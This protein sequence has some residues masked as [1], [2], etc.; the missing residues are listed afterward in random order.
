VEGRTEVMNRLQASSDPDVLPEAL[1]SMNV[2]GN[3]HPEE[4][5]DDVSDQIKTLWR[6]RAEKLRKEIQKATDRR[7]T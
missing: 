5:W 7:I 6:D 2:S 1:R 3:G 4:P